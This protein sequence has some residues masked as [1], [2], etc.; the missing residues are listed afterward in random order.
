MLK[1]NTPA[2][3]LAA[4]AVLALAA[5]CDLLLSPEKK[6]ERIERAMASGDYREAEVRA[7]A[8]VQSDPD[9]LRGRRLLGEISFSRG[10]IARADQEFGRLLAAGSGDTEVRAA[11]A[12]IKLLQGRNEEALEILSEAPVRDFELDVL[13]V[14]ALIA[15]GQRLNARRRLAALE[16]GTPRDESRVARLTGRIALLD[17][18]NTEA[19]AELEKAASLDPQSAE[20]RF[21]LAEAQFISGRFAAAERSLQEAAALAREAHNA[22]LEFRA[23]AVLAELR[24]SDRDPEKAAQYVSRLRE[25]NPRHPISMFLQGGLQIGTGRVEHGV[26]TLQVAVRDYPDMLPSLILLG[27]TNIALGNLEQAG[28]YLQQARNLAPENIE[29]RRSLAELELARGRPD[30]AIEILDPLII[31]GAE[32]PGLLAT[33]GEAKLATGDVKGAIEYMDRSLAADPSNEAAGL[34]LAKAL[35]IDGQKERADEVLGRFQSDRAV[36][37][38]IV[39]D[40]QAGDT[41]AARVAALNAIAASRDPDFGRSLLLAIATTENGSDIV[42]AAS[43]GYLDRFPG[44][45]TAI[46]SV[47]QVLALNGNTDAAEQR[48]R[49]LLGDPDY[50]ARAAFELARVAAA[51]GND[52]DVLRW[53]Q[54]S[55]EFDPEA[56]E[57]RIALSRTYVERGE[58]DAAEAVLSGVTADDDES[59]VAL[60]MQRAAVRSATGDYEAALRILN[61]LRREQPANA[62]IILQLGRVTYQQQDYEG[63]MDWFQ[64]AI[65]RNPN[66]VAARAGLARAALQM[67]DFETAN[68]N[69][70][71]LQK[72][73]PSDATGFVLAAESHL[74]RGQ[75]A[76]AAE[77]FRE[78]YA[79]RP[80]RRA[81]IRIA[82][83]LGRSGA[84][85]WDTEILDWLER[86]P[87]DT[88][89]RFTFA[90]VLQLRDKHEEAVIEFRR[91][92]E[93]EPSNAA[94]QN[95]L[96]WSLFQLGDPTALDAAKRAL[97]LLPESAAIADTAGWIMVRTGQIGE[98][99]ALLR[100]AA[101]KAPDD[102]DILYHLAWALNENGDASA[103]LAHVETALRAAGEGD[104]RDAL[105][106]LQQ[107]INN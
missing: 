37:A 8:F 56:I 62:A 9:D 87:N 103:A 43:A 105:L 49:T 98:G 78:A 106:E 65:D 38:R 42:D 28:M 51:A 2:I 67:G 39:A 68:E 31:A 82:Q 71:Y 47:A 45:S 54:Q 102:P 90:N 80:E 11:Y 48:F 61:E 99:I 95:N 52:R 6:L 73:F 1:R 85:G 84:D 17:G 59:D 27:T 30:V 5:G 76:T 77:Y 35:R 16:P 23:T 55:I 20:A 29:V 70:L 75:P 89:A 14:E 25:I 86:A 92:A 97:E 104:R 40:L 72:E 53:L 93:V 26:R 15:S 83:V 21:T 63:A 64:R 4:A 18:D 60:S 12:R 96:A 66:S 58:T 3:A 57:P 22:L 36:L 79:I 44:N 7:K 50:A 10:D 81:A 100:S 33:Y 74:R 88:S 46:F 94:V 69:A 101:E 34:E 24:V 41:A 107:G 91:L 19:L 32:Q 13:E